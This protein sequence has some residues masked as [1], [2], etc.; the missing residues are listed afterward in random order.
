MFINEVRGILFLQTDHFLYNLYLHCI[1][2]IS[3]YLIS[4]FIST[5]D[6]ICLSLN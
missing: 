5:N 1:F 4:H 2:K 6:P 3:Q